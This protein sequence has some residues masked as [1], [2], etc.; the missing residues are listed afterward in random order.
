MVALRRSF[1]ENC[2]LVPNLWVNLFSLT[3]NLRKGWNLRNEGLKFVLTKKDF[4]IAFDR[5]IK[6]SHGHVNGIELIPVVNMANLTMERGTVVDI[7][8]FH[9]SMGHVHEDSLQKWR[10]IMD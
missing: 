4:R 6:T 3:Q 10:T 2:K 7:N 8:D 5:I 9:R 1:L